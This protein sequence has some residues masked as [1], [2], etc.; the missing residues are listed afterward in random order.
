M[1][2]TGMAPMEFQPAFSH[3]SEFFA[4]WTRRSFRAGA[5]ATRSRNLDRVGVNI[6][7]SSE[8]EF[9]TEVL[10]YFVS[11]SWSLFRVVSG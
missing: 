10:S 2:F 7:D 6:L 8:L 5:K 1:S 3:P 9:L 11:F 4:L